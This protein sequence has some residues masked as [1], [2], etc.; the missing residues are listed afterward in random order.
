M[1]ELNVKR[2]VTPLITKN[3]DKSNK[4]TINKLKE[5]LLDSIY[6]KCLNKISPTYCESIMN[7]VITSLVFKKYN[8]NETLLKYNELVSK[9]YL[10]FKGQL[11]IYKV[12][13]EKAENSLDL[14]SQEYHHDK[15]EVFQYF[16][17]CLKKYLKSINVENIFMSN[18]KSIYNIIEND[19]EETKNKRAKKFEELYKKIIISSK[20]LDY[21]LTEGKIFGEEFLYNNIPFC[22]CIL[23]CGSDC[24]IGELNRED[25]DKIYRRFNKIERSYITIFLVNLKLFNPANYFFSKLQQCLIKR[26]Y[27]KNEIIF[28][29]GDKFHAF[30]LIRYGKINLSL[31][32]HKTVNCDLEPD[33]IMGNLKKE[34]FTSSKSYI[35]KGK[36]SENIDY[37]LLTLQNGEF[38]GDIEY[39]GKKDKYICSAQCI[40]DSLVFEID[41]ELFEHFIINNHN[42][43]NNLKG[44][45]E[46][47][48]EKMKLFQERI[49]S[50]KMNNSAI[51]KSDYILSKNKFTRNI[52]QG[53]PLKED[54]KNNY[55]LKANNSNISKNT[56]KNKIL[57]SNEEFYLNM[58]VPI[59]KRHSSSNKSKKFTKIKFNND[60]FITNNKEILNNQ[61]TNYKLKDVFSNSHSSF[62]KIN[63]S[64]RLLT[65]TN[66]P[67]STNRTQMR[68]TNI[69]IDQ[70]NSERK[71][72]KFFFPLKSSYIPNITPINNN[73]RNKK[74][75]KIFVKYNNKTQ[76][77]NEK[78]F[79]VMDPNLIFSQTDKNKNIIQ[80]LKSTKESKIYSQRYDKDKIRKINNYYYKSPKIIK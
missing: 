79:D 4:E 52:L 35:T 19:K 63:I 28:N 70:N 78:L 26:Y 3:W 38:I 69:L 43:N 66:E 6:F 41:I 34:R 76:N 1:F 40:E 23:E 36:Y 15:D 16:Q 31:K 39:L 14:I 46:K 60:F 75:T 37:N 58:I 73:F 80:I 49:Y 11:N 12:S 25:Y 21:T 30:Y 57:D 9:Y 7:G 54:K 20:E 53:Y 24:I 68:N 55:L 10:I 61:K 32:I 62:A 33:I 44:F 50:I 48:K 27:S 8:K 29:Q 42:V 22:N 56:N 67:Q 2:T 47:I 5:I 17:T 77:D 59:L 71:R 51:K 18:Y 64:N 74:S 65:E 72:K 13:M 45:Y